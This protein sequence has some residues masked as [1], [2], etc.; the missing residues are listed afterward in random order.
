MYKGQAEH[1]GRPGSRPGVRNRLWR[2]PRDAGAAAGIYAHVG[3]L[4]RGKPAFVRRSHVVVRGC[5]WCAPAAAGALRIDGTA[6]FHRGTTLL[7][8]PR[9]MRMAATMS[10]V[11]KLAGV[12]VKTVSNFHN[13][14]PYM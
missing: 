10:D 6:K 14:Y 8:R 7:G 4:G 1:A 9:R 5:G 13:G 2:P 3:L 11:A 12:S